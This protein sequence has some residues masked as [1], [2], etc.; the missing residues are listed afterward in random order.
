MSDAPFGANSEKSMAASSLIREA[1]A[2]CRAMVN[3]V[4]GP[5]KPNQ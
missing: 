2:P 1:A 4:T 5:S 3:L